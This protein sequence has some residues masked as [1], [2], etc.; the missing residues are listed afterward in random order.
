MSINCLIDSN[1][2]CPF[3]NILFNSKTDRIKM[4]SEVSKI[5]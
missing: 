3:H 2:V 5:F 4:S 1:Y